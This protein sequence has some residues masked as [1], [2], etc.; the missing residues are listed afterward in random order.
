MKS[1]AKAYLVQCIISK[2]HGYLESVPKD[3]KSAVLL[4]NVYVRISQVQVFCIDT[5]LTA[6]T[7]RNIVLLE[8]LNINFIVKCGFINQ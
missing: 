2:C 1:R 6:S 4:I 8:Y 3:K 7:K 5:Y